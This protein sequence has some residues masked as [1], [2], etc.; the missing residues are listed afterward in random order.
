[1]ADIEVPVAER[2][3]FIPVNRHKIKQA[4]LELAT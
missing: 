2:Q 4:L 3:H 1:M